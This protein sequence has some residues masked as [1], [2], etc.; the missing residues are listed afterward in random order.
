M[1]T[2]LHVVGFKSLRDTTVEL[3]TVNVFIGANGSGK[4]NLLEAVGVAGAAA[5]RAV[6]PEALRYRGVRP[7][8]PALYKSSFSHE[9]IRR[10]IT[11]ECGSAAAL[12]RVGLDNPIRSNDP[13]PW[14]IHSETLE[15]DG[16]PILTRAPRGTR[17]YLPELRRLKA[18]PNETLAQ[19][20]LQA[21][22]EP[23]P[24][25]D[26]IERLTDYAVYS[27][28][29]AVLRG[30][31]GDIARPPLGLSGGGLPLAVRDLL[32]RRAGTFGPFDLDEL[33]DLIDWA[34]DVQAVASDQATISPAVSTTPTVLRFRDRFM[35]PSRNTLSAY[36]A[37]EGALYVLFL[38]ALACHPEAPRTFAVDN[39][40]TALHPRLARELTRRVCEFL[41]EDGTRQVLLTTHN[42][43]V[44]DGLNLLDDRIRLFAVE[45]ER[46]GSSTV[47]RIRLSERILERLEDGTALSRLWVMGRL[48]GMPQ[49]L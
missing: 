33:W 13:G 40:D 26:L 47:R 14:R 49:Y 1:L 36:D 7:G 39:F 3:G 41:I 4:S 43:L 48:G 28:A 12:Y 44:L 10:V 29:T 17:V 37:S 35:S 19:L 6:E 9:P 16:E 21:A 22:G 31:V 30:L 18:R 45:R 20:A 27:P 46:T 2:S 11:L 5:F 15:S 42:P 8:L 24:A 32:N 38:L 34:E 25:R 23:E